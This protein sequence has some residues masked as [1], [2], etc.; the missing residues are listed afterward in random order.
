MSAEADIYPLHAPELAD[1]IDGGI[2]EGSMF[3]K[4]YGYYAQGVGPETAV[5]PAGWQ[6]RLH[7]V[8]NANTDS[9]IGWCLDVLD[10]FM[11]KAV[12]ARDKDLV[13]CRALLKFGHVQLQQALDLVPGMPISADVRRRLA[14]RIRRWA[15]Q[16]G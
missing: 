11:S 9:R 13:F 14:A 10:L 16:T 5:L 6:D 3:H 1:Q 7:K 12:A 4:T 15:K 8:Q 2:G